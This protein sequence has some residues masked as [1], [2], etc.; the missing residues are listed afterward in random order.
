LALEWKRGEA[1][2]KAAHT[3]TQQTLYT[4][5]THTDECS[6]FFIFLPGCLRAYSR[7]CA[8][9]CVCVQRRK[10]VLGIN[11]RPG[12]RVW[13]YSK[14]V[15]EVCWCPD[16]QPDAIDVRSQVSRSA[17]L[18]FIWHRS[19][20]VYINQSGFPMDIVSNPQPFRAG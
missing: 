3:H 1:I 8:G 13:L 5:D 20:S 11:M 19:R 7:C 16:Y 17:T 4:A 18:L 10:C 12:P 6:F 15:H 14:E 2:S 9:L